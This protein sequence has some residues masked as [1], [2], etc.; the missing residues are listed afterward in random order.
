LIGLVAVALATSATG[1]TASAMA[2]TLNGAGSTLIAPLESQWANSWGPS[3]GNTVNYGAVGSGTGL[4]DIASGVVDFG[5]SDAPLS[6][7]TTACNGCV[8]IPWGLTA[9]AL[10]FHLNGVQNVNLSGP[11]IAQIFLGQITSWNDARIARL[12]KGTSLPATAIVPV[13]RSDSSGDTYAFTDFLSRVSGAWKSSVGTGTSVGFPTTN[14]GKGNSGIAGVVTSTNG[15]IGYIS[16]SYLISQGIPAAR[17]QN[18]AGKFVKPNLNNISAA[19]STVHSVPGSN[20]LH[21]VYPTKRAKLAYP[22]STF[23]YVIVK[24]GEAQ[25]GLLKSFITYALTTG[26]RFGP[27]LDFARIPSVVLNAAKSTLAS[28]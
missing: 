12:N 28:L 4:K 7:S 15:A 23:T 3:T 6:A 9:T 2:G 25:I 13:H 5:A 26:Q 19:A 11:V 27:A 18:A 21:I 8:Q 1:M 10:G 24:H 16:A 20:E 17:V 14:A 22:I